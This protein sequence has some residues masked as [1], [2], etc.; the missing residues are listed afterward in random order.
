MTTGQG[1]LDRLWLAVP[2]VS[3]GGILV[4]ALAI[5]TAGDPMYVDHPMWAIGLWANI[6]ASF[7]LCAYAYTRPRKDF[8]ALLA[9]MYAVIIFL[10]GDFS[11]GP[12]MQVLFAASI[13]ILAVRVEKKF[14]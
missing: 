11:T 13:T 6:A 9:P 7:M 14:Q 1:V 2:V 4:S 3:F 10:A 12:I 5:F 8:V